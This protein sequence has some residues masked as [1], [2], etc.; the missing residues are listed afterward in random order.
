M[1]E[2]PVT[3]TGTA[4]NAKAGAILV[5]AGD[6]PV[7]VEGLRAWP[8]EDLGKELT[9]TGFLRRKRIYPEA[10]PERQGMV[11]TPL[12]LELT[13]PRRSR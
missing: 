8:A 11:G 2:S 3:I 5:T 7:Y 4:E 10:T 1:S 6:R 12:V 13:E 9:L